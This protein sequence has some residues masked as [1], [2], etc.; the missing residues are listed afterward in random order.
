MTDQWFFQQGEFE[1]GPLRPRELLEQVRRGNI[2]PETLVRKGDSAW[3][4]ASAVNG[5]FD[6]ARKPVTV[7]LCPNCNV[8]ITKPPV[9]CKSCERHI[10]K[11]ATQK[12]QS[13]LADE[14]APLREKMIGG[15]WSNWLSRL[16]G[17][18]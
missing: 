11:A 12:R 10:E 5:L 3:T 14:D 8:E 2:R 1:I 15:A 16:R 6:A 18:R 7:Y 13:Q 17:D 4:K 9:Y